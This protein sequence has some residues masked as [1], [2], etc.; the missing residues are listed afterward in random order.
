MVSLID[1]D[2]TLPGAMRLVLELCEGGELY[3]RIQQK[4]YYPEHEARS[5]VSMPFYMER[6][7]KPTSILEM[8]MAKIA[9]FQAKAAVRNLLEA[10][11]YIHSH[12]IM[13]R[14]HELVDIPWFS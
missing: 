4:Q 10:V 11:A 14:H 12:G 8:S 3:D 7:L 9:A 1:V 13:H 2:E 6:R 5:S